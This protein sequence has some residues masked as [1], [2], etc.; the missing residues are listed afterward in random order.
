MGIAKQE[1][2]QHLTEQRPSQ[3]HVISELV[4]EA[5]PGV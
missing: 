1:G 2:S 3:T 5:P 4:S